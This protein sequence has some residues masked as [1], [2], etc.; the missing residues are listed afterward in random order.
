M[1]LQS[2]CRKDTNFLAIAISIIFLVMFREAKAESWPSQSTPEW[3]ELIAAAKVE[4]SLVLLASPILDD[5][6]VKKFKEDTGLSIS[7]VAGGG[8]DGRTRFF[9]EV[10]SGNPTVD[11]FLGGSS[12]LTL[13]QNGLLTPVRPLL[14]LPEVTVQEN[15][16]TGK[17]PYV[18]EDGIFLPVPSMY[19]SG[20]VLVNSDLVDPATINLWTD[21]LD[22]S[23]SGKVASHDVRVTGGGQAVAN[24][25]TKVAG[26]DFIEKLF[27]GQDVALTRDYRQAT[28]WVARGTY[29]IALSA[30]PRDIDKYR[31]QGLDNLVVLEM[32]DFPGYL[33][34]GSS[35]LTIAKNAPHPNASAVFANWY[36][37]QRGQ[38][39]YSSVNKTPSDRLDVRDGPWPKYIEPLQNVEYLNQYSEEWLTI[40]KA[41]LTAKLLKAVGEP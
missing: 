40:H 32:T 25:L 37:S 9:R 10:E 1:T 28:D 31:A 8:R 14:I 33:V 38:E 21:L 30:L 7:L 18:D 41:E 27:L 22:E 17:I 19:V 5:E 6:F 4:E 23:L 12:N 20:R 24:Y 13:T 26:I 39:V 35:V 15:W 2:F 29:A 34:G 16:R 3:E 11:I 36:L